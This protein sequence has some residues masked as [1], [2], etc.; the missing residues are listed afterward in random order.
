MDD[1]TKA[2]REQLK[3]AW[4][5]QLSMQNQVVPYTC[6]EY[7][8]HCHQFHSEE[9]K[10]LFTEESWEPGAEAMFFKFYL[11]AA[12]GPPHL[13]LPGERR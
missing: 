5:Q 13:L 11:E 7:V 9:R 2:L 3:A 4:L 12:S 8:E 6:E 10:A 1:Q